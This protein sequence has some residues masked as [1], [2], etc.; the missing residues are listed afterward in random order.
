VSC[1]TTTDCIAVG[2]PSGSE[3]GLAEQWDGKTWSALKTPNGT[4]NLDSVSCASATSCMAVGTTEGSSQPL[5]VPL[6]ESWDGKKWSVTHIPNPAGS[7]QADVR[8]VSCLS[9]EDCVAVGESLNDLQV[10]SPLI[11]SW[12]GTK[13]TIE[14]SASVS[15]TNLGL[16]GV[17]CASP[18]GCLAVGYAIDKLGSPEAFSEIWNG[19]NWTAEK[20]PTPSGGAE[21]AG[22]QCSS[23][24]TCVT[25]GA[26][27]RGA[28]AEEWDGSEWT[29]QKTTTPVGAGTS[30]AFE[31]VSCVS[32]G[33]C[34]A[35]GSY[36]NSSG[37]E[38]TLAEAT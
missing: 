3:I 20:T 7:F 30:A 24:T 32:S 1:I 34:T 2:S 10:A 16:T 26:R 4:G 13:W 31:G 17:S 12:N 9:A 27:S 22:V 11:Y 18:T 33:S 14:T 29:I 21:P 23:A 19:K 8:G 37:L 38:L 6:A 15:L 5:P 36:S 25:V 35:V 28:L